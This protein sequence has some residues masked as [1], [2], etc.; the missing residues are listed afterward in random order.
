MKSRT[1]LKSWSTELGPQQIL[2]S[3]IHDNDNHKIQDGGYPQRKRERRE[4]GLES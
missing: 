4:T 1:E 2:T 3:I